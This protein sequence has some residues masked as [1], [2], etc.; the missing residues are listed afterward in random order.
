MQIDHK[1]SNDKN[2][3]L[4]QSWSWKG[5]VTYFYNSGTP[6]YLENGTS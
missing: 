5:H 1:G 3:K 4:S 2:A 6:L